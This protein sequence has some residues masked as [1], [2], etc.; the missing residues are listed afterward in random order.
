MKCV[1]A[2]C[3]SLWAGWIFAAYGGQETPR[4]DEKFLVGMMKY[5]DEDWSEALL[6]I[7]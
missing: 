5:G 6:Y 7:R 1:L 2:I 4:F 3:L